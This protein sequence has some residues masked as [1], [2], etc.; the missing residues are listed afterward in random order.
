MNAPDILIAAADC[1]GDRASERDKPSGERSMAHTVSMFNAY[2]DSAEGSLSELD[3]WMFMVFLK[4]ARAA[5]GNFREDDYIDGAGYMALAG[6][7][8]DPMNEQP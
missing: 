2:R 3:G 1:I 4:I 7:C 5:G 8:A 6:E